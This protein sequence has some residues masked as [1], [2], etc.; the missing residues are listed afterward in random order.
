MLTQASLIDYFGV[1]PMPYFFFVLV[2]FLAAFGAFV[3]TFL[4]AAVFLAATRAADFLAATGAAFFAVALFFTGFAVLLFR[5]RRRFASRGLSC[6]TAENGV[7]I[8]CVLLVRSNSCYRHKITF[9][10]C[11]TCGLNAGLC[12]Y[13]RNGYIPIRSIQLQVFRVTEVRRDSS[14]SSS[15]SSFWTVDSS[16]IDFLVI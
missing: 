8:R 2:T 6:T 7:P 3:A 13:Q 14:I 12:L 15:R 9:Q 1:E 5:L 16:M 10:K 4:G 11:S